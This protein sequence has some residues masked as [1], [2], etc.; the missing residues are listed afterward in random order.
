MDG[1]GYLYRVE[2]DKEVREFS[3][4]FTAK[5]YQSGLPP[6]SSRSVVPRT[7]ADQVTSEEART[8]Q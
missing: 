7:V 5:Q 3:D 1:R 2:S 8:A 4:E 6:G